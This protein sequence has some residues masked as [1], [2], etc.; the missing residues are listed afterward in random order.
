MR[1][2]ADEMAGG[3]GAVYVGDLNQ[4][5]GPSPDTGWTDGYQMVSLDA[6]ER[7]L[8]IYESK[9]YQYLIRKAR[10]DDPT[11]TT[12][13]L[14]SPITIEFT[15]VNRALIWCDL[16]ERYFAQNLSRRTAG[17]VEIYMTSFAELGFPG[18]NSLEWLRQGSLQMAEVLGPLVGPYMPEMD[19]LSLYGLY[20]SREQQFRAVEN[21]IPELERL[22]VGETGGVS[23]GVNWANGGDFYLFSREPVQLLEHFHSKETR[24]L[25]S[26]MSD[27]LEAMGASPHFFAYEEVY[28]HIDGGYLDAAVTIAKAGHDQKWYEV[29][30]YLAG[31]VVSW[32]VS[33]SVI[34]GEKWNN[35][36]RDLQ[37]II[38]EEAA[39][40]E[41]EALRLSAIQNDY[42]LQLLQD[43]G[44]EFIHFGPEIQR[45]S[46]KAALEYVVP[47]WV[48]RLGGPEAPFVKLFNRIHELLIGV[49]IEADGTVVKTE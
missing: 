35:I 5:V 41:L 47:N 31:P 6:L 49:R 38:K 37:E 13:R 44:M 24:S 9:Y 16:A 4:L 29:S 22:V 39:K 10:L 17:Q 36:P 21:A 26:S 27:W 3:P 25:N 1:R 30:S 7:H 8:Y 19:I 2:Y 34:N 32:P 40:L 46:E 15:C 23:I 12:S 33:F 42:G 14:E 11:P 18:H 45:A 48:K 43:A 28:S 20:S